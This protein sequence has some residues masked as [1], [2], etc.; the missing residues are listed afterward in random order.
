[1]VAASRCNLLSRSLPNYQ[2]EVL[3]YSDTV[4]N[5][6]HNLLVDLR[7]HHH[8]Q[9]KVRRVL[10][11]IRDLEADELPFN[12][13]P[14][15]DGDEFSSLNLPEEP[16]NRPL[17]AGG[18]DDSLLDL[19]AS[20]KHPR[21][22]KVGGAK[23]SSSADPQTTGKGGV[24][25]EELRRRQED[26]VQE[27]FRRVGD[28]F[29]L[30]EVAQQA[31]VKDLVLGGIEAELKAL[32]N[33]VLN[34]RETTAGPSRPRTT[35]SRPTDVD[36]AAA[37]GGVGEESEGGVSDEIDE[38]LKLSDGN[39]AADD[40]SPLSGAATGPGSGESSGQDKLVSEWDD[41]SS[42]MPATRD[43]T[44]SPLSGWEQELL[45]STGAPSLDSI[46]TPSVAPSALPPATQGPENSSKPPVADSPPTSDPLGSAAS[47][48][49]PPPRL[50]PPNG[51]STG[52]DKDSAPSSEMDVS[53]DELLGLGGGSGKSADEASSRAADELLM[54]ELQ[55]LGIS[56]PK[57]SQSTPQGPAPVPTPQG[58]TPA[59]LASIDPA[60]FQLHSAQSQLP[61]SVLPANSASGGQASPF[62][63]PLGMSQCPPVFPT[64]GGMGMAMAPPK[65]GLVPPSGP[66]GG[67]APTAQPQMVAKGDEGDK[68][69]KGTA[70]MNFFAHLDPLVN[71]K[72]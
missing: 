71:E 9:Y 21:A 69:Q 24:D 45:D 68:G 49:E 56:P 36:S 51:T 39:D 18:D 61:P 44:K 27:P 17:F 54:S 43:H 33:E 47:V 37:Q 72:A 53:V 7:T 28:P 67:V 62:R 60:L 22:G 13:Q 12:D 63:S 26:K 14:G 41:F 48:T 50:H 32:Q 64:Q 2:K 6:F 5:E 29:S 38:L 65:F 58:P 40:Q 31:K 59:G 34:P 55:S 46:L 10:E 25:L 11:E 8:H 15:E 42:F 4:A 16:Q 1:M 70:W 57:V 52:S 66:A 3:G 35:Q 23:D 19:G 20:N 30:E